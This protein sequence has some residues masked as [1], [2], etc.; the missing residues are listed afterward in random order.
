MVVNT[1]KG[2]PPVLSSTVPSGSLDLAAADD[3]IVDAASR[4]SACR[5]P[6]QPQKRA[7]VTVTFTAAG[8]VA[9]A[10]IAGIKFNGVTLR[11]CMGSTFLGAR[12]PAFNGPSVT[13][14]KTLKL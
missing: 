1:T 5:R 3:A 2:H 14:R 8:R 4:A 13:V 6:E 11:N 9:S 12:V 10:N 7:T